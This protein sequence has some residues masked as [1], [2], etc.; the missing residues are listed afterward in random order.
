MCARH[1]FDSRVREPRTT[2]KYTISLLE[3]CARQILHW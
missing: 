3:M 2:P 1:E